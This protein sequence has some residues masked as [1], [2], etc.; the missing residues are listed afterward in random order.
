MQHHDAMTGTHVLAVGKDYLDMMAKVK[1]DTL[2]LEGSTLA[3]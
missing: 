1:K 3:S 2:G